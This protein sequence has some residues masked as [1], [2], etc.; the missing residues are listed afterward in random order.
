[1]TNSD[2]LVDWR[3]FFLMVAG[4][5]ASLAGLL[6]VALS[7]HLRHITTSPLYRYRARLSLSTL[8]SVLVMASLVL[9]PR[10]DALA[11]ALKETFPL[12]AQIMIVVAGLL[13]LRRAGDPSRR[14]PYVLRTL[15]GLLLV[16]VACTGNVVLATGRWVGLEVLALCCLLFLVWMIFNAWALVIG[17]ADE[18]SAQ[19]RG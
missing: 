7:I 18:T 8:M 2:L 13:E 1:M 12:S 5:S 14:R 17:L 16:I 6:F 3:P 10:Q 15:V 11:L 4:A 19:L 9:I